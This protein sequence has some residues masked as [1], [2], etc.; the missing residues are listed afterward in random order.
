MTTIAKLSKLQFHVLL[1]SCSIFLVIFY[2]Q[3]VD[4][5]ASL[6]EFSYGLVSVVSHVGS[7]ASVGMCV[8]VLLMNDLPKNRVA[9]MPLPESSHCLHLRQV[10]VFT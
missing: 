3:N 8:V 6:D 10:N 2:M 5:E 7:S 9:S 1:M 4:A